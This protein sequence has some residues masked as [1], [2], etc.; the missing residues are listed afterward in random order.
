MPTSKT[1]T[2][3]LLGA[4]G[5][6][7][8]WLSAQRQAVAAVSQVV[9]T[10]SSDT[11]EAENTFEGLA[12]SE[13]IDL[14]PKW[15]EQHHNCYAAGLET[16]VYVL[17]DCGLCMS[18]VSVQYGRI[19]HFTTEVERRINSDGDYSK[20]GCCYLVPGEGLGISCSSQSTKRVLPRRRAWKT[21]GCGASDIGSTK[22]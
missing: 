4:I 6:M 5:L 19:T 12:S 1:L 2:G 16:D 18:D 3:I 11:L 22:S 14:G 17:V 21:L 9:R 15:I 7:V 8:I 13:F 10:H 20:Q